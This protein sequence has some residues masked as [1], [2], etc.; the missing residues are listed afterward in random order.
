[1]AEG[2]PAPSLVK[3]KGATPKAERVRRL[4][5]KAS[6][7]SLR[8]APLPESARNPR[9]AQVP[10]HERT[11]DRGEEALHPHLKELRDRLVVSLIGLGVAFIVTYSF[12]E[13]IF[14]FLMRPFIEVMPA[15]E[16]LHIHEHHRGV[17]YLFQ[18]SPVAAL[19]LAAPVIL[20]EVWMFVS[21]GLYEKEKKYIAPFIIFGSIFFIIGALFCYYVT[22][23]VSTVSS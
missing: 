1:M 20:Y 13:R 8:R 18:G 3:A 5:A 22:M 4:R 12:K 14:H 19:F 23:P 7:K 9:R 2:T 17:H 15:E 16:L 11:H 21:P 10:M 6:R